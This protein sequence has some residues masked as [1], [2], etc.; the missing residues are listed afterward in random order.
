M[1]FLSGRESLEQRLE[2]RVSHGH[3]IEKKDLTSIE[4]RVGSPEKNPN[5]GT[6]LCSLRVTYPHH[7]V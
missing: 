2:T 4:H 3:G 5:C 1:A 6:A 7:L